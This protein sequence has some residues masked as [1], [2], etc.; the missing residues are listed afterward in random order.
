MTLAGGFCEVDFDDLQFFEKCGGGTFGSVYRALW[1]SQDMIV[2][3]KKLLALDKEATVL[4]VLSHRNVMQFY[5]AVVEEPNF[6]LI[7]EYATNGSLYAYLQNPTNTMDFQH[8]LRWAREIAQ[9]MN[10]LHDEAPMKIIHRDLKSKNVV[11]SHDWICKICDFGASRFMGSTTK[12]SLAG[13]FPWM[14]PEVIQSLPVSESC[15][16]WS[17][18]VV[19]WELLTHEVPFKGIEGFQVAWLVVERGERLTIPST[20][21]A[22]FAKLMEDCWYVDPKQRPSFRDLLS[23]LHTMLNDESLPE[24][25]NSFLDHR[26]VWRKEIEATIDRLKKAERNITLKEQ[27][28]RERENKIKEREKSLEQQF[29]V[30][31]LD[32]YDVN[33]WREVDVYQWVRQLHNG[34]TNDLAMY[35]DLFI[36][37]HITGR[38]LLLMTQT[39]LK[40]MGIT[41]VGHILELFTEIELLKAHNHRLLNF[42]P[43]SANV[44]NKERAASPVNRKVT[45]TFIFGH[46]LRKG[47]SEKDHKWKMYMEMDDEDEE[48]DKDVVPITLIKSV[49]FICSSNHGI[50][51]ID[52]PPFIMEKW[53]TGLGPDIEVE[54]NVQFES[55]VKKPKSIKYH[56]KLD[57]SVTT[58]GQKVVILTLLST[59]SPPLS[60]D[61]LPASPARPSQSVSPSAH[62]NQTSPQLQGYWNKRQSLGTVSLPESIKSN[63]SSVWA[64]VVSGRK[65]SSPAIFSSV[66]A[67]PIPGTPL[68]LYPFHPSQTPPSSPSLSATS[69]PYSQGSSPWSTPS[70]AQHVLRQ[71]SPWFHTNQ[72]SQVPHS[73]S[74]ESSFSSHNVTSS[75]SSSSGGKSTKHDNSKIS[76]DTARDLKV[77]FVISEPVSS[78]GQDTHTNSYADVCNRCLCQRQPTAGQAKQSPN[79]QKSGDEGYNSSHHESND[80]RSLHDNKDGFHDN[81]GGNHINR[82]HRGRYRGEDRHRYRDNRNDY[83]DN[84]RYNRGKRQGRGDGR[85]RGHYSVHKVRGSQRDVLSGGDYQR[86]FSDPKPR[87]GSFLSDGD[88]SDGGKANSYNA[89]D[90]KPLVKS[91]HRGRKGKNISQCLPTSPASVGPSGSENKDSHHSNRAETLDDGS[92]ESHKERGGGWREVDHRHSDNAHNHHH[93]YGRTRGRGYRRND[94]QSDDEKNMHHGYSSSRG[95]NGDDDRRRHYSD[96]EARGRGHNGRRGR[97]SEQYCPDQSTGRAHPQK[98][99]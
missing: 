46:H 37:N 64:S 73:S 99:V 11:I 50:F 10:Y 90:S 91:Q 15:D 60:V 80:R 17:Y 97:E 88:L 53:Q 66:Q 75:D 45:V 81:R 87:T 78:D 94:Y 92:L 13:T 4:S 76:R 30:V 98:K 18:G 54:C 42:P 93:N 67:K 71:Q 38:R 26:E 68:V 55:T 31:K 69:S 19:L 22:T 35:A 34:H 83:Y 63:N 43:L 70:P 62:G 23:R 48:E 56:H 86:S 14:A 57:A 65:P 25:T 2:A 47:T 84:Q 7:T 39:D 32:S 82:G 27:E 29:K 77:S 36:N 52:H 44:Q 33:S 72:L 24:E 40:N 51:K 1:K 5:G 21:P 79:L 49:S 28:L 20:C 41:S 12:M 3:V 95:Y 8:I 85:G 74:Q 9:G 58:S 96:G 61:T 16:T 89:P 59:E 6:C